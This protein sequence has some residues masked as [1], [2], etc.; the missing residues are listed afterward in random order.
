MTRDGPDEGGPE[1]HSGAVRDK[2]GRA[3]A[4]RAR[5]HVKR[6]SKLSAWMGSMRAAFMAG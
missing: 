1:A 5:E 6:Y 3:V 4:P 2:E